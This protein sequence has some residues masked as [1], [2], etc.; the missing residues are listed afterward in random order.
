[1]FWWARRRALEAVEIK[2]AE[3]R[4]E[5]STLDQKLKHEIEEIR[6]KN[7]LE[8]KEFETLIKLKAEQ[9][10]AKLELGFEKKE[11][12]LEAGLTKQLQVQELKYEKTLNKLKTDHAEKLADL[13][14][15]TAE[16]YHNKMDDALKE[17]SLKGSAQALFAQDMALKLLEKPSLPA[18]QVLRTENVVETKGERR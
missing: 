13:R 11:A 10:A 15:T 3:A 8:R 4:A 7:K 9:D 18:V 17:M 12:S 6:H 2:L 5:V 1:M 16:S 14:A